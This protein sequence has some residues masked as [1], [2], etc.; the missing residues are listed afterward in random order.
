M[1]RILSLTPKRSSSMGDEAIVLVPGTG[2]ESVVKAATPLALADRLV[3][4]MPVDYDF[5]ATFLL[6]FREF[7]SP[8]ELLAAL[9]AA[10]AK[11]GSAVVLRIADIL[12]DWIG[13][14]W[15]IDFA[16][17]TDF[18]R[19]IMSFVHDRVSADDHPVIAPRLEELVQSK[20]LPI[21]ESF[22][23][24]MSPAHDSS[25]TTPARRA[26]SS[27]L[28]APWLA[29]SGPAGSMGTGSG[30]HSPSGAEPPKPLLPK[31]LRRSVGP[32]GPSGGGGGGNSSPSTSVFSNLTGA[33]AVP[34]IPGSASPSSYTSSD[35]ASIIVGGGSDHFS[36][37]V[38]LNAWFIGP[39]RPSGLASR[40]TSPLSLSATSSSEYAHGNGGVL[41]VGGGVVVGAYVIRFAD[42]EILEVAR[43][44]TLLETELFRAVSPM[45]LVSMAWVKSNKDA[46]SPTIV[47]MARWSN[48]V[49]Q[50]AVSEILAVR[51]LRARAAV[52]ERFI[53][54]AQEL[55]R[56]GNF[57][58]VKEI[59][60][61]LSSSAIHRL[62]KTRGLASRKSLKTLD[63]LN[64]I[65]LPALNSKALRAS[66]R[67]AD[68]PMV[69]FPGII[70]TD[71]V[72]VTTV[73]KN[74]DDRGR[75]HFARFNKIAALVLEWIEWQ[76]HATY[77]LEPVPA[78]ATYLRDAKTWSEDDAYARSLVCEPR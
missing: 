71:L 20:L 27:L 54:L 44:L 33:S 56:L 77:N 37:T 42:L 69:P 48:H 6:T 15:T 19:E 23:A 73:L 17:D 58:G 25:I 45:E 31:F 18:L 64:E 35:V 21:P 65:V 51:D 12:H 67:A 47:R 41:A 62:K 52:F 7:M 5:R 50:W 13:R 60:A 70:Q 68:P 16:E 43:Q 28:V 40:F 9:E 34:S 66:M 78:I 4:A 1:H 55:L 36:E 11:A 8:A 46:G 53:L 63:S 72:F 24:I 49:V 10:Y 29:L 76:E 3:H 30:P 2:G 59:L 32:G 39:S 14:Y 74:R 22:E 26:S 57:N 75:V 38:P 61:A